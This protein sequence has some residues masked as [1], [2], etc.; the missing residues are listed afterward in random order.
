MFSDWRQLP[1]A[2]D[3]IQSGGWVWRGIVPWDK[4]EGSRPQK[5]WYRSQAEYVILG[6][7]GPRRHAGEDAV[8]L[9]GVFRHPVLHADKFHITGKPVAIMKSLL[10]IIPKGGLIL[11]PFA[12]SGTTLIAARELGIRSIGIEI[13]TSYLDVIKNRCCQ[14]LPLSAP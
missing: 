9:P 4:T 5:G 12:G 1:I 8:C 7:A 6:T 10:P 13:E 11:D 3:A 2:T 14:L